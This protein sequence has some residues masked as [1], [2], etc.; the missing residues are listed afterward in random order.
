LD[1]PIAWIEEVIVETI[2]LGM[3]VL[4][5]VALTFLL[6]E[7]LI[8]PAIA[9]LGEFPAPKTRMISIGCQGVHWEDIH[10][11]T[12]PGAFTTSLPATAARNLGSS[13]AIIGHSEERDAKYQIINQFN[14]Q[15]EWDERLRIKAFEAIDRLVQAEVQNALQAGLNVLL[16]V[17]E[18]AEQRGGGNFEEQKLRIEATLRNQLLTNMEGAKSILDEQKI[19]IAYEPI[20]ALGPD[21]ISPR[22]DYISFV[23][24]FIKRVILVNMGIPTS[25]VYAGNLH[26][27]N[28]NVVAEI[29]TIDGG[30][31]S[32]TQLADPFS[33][34]VADLKPIVDHFLA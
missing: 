26:E 9:A 5:N 17:G 4:D 21:K 31:V 6:P 20:W 2:Q 23:A 12:T 29:D 28:A 16:C 10:S 34:E 13:W 3:G 18:T 7:S 8:S 32:L 25:V 24:A 19:V 22:R 30:L 11:Q 1:D 33:F 15:I 14:P 27:E